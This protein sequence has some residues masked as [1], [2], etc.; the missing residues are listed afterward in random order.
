MADDSHGANA[1]DIDGIRQDIYLGPGYHVV[2]GYLS[3][4][5]VDHIHSFWQTHHN[6]QSGTHVPVAVEGGSDFSR[7]TPELDQHF[8]YFWNRPLDQFTYVSA[9]DLQALRNRIEGNDPNLDFLPH[10]FRNRF[11]SEYY[12]YAAYRLTATRQG[13][14]IAGH[15]DWPLNHARVQ[16]SLMLSSFGEDYDGGL[17]FDTDMHGGSEINLCR[18]ENLKKGDLVIFRYFHKHGVEAVTTPE[19]KPGFCRL[20]MPLNYLPVKNPNALSSIPKRVFRKLPEPAKNLFRTRRPAAPA[21]ATSTQQYKE[22]R[23]DDHDPLFY[24]DSDVEKLM[25]IAV[26]EGVDP[27]EVYYHRGLWARWKMMADWQFDWL[28]NH[29]LKPEHQFLD[30]GC[31]P[32]RLGINLVPYLEDGHYCGVDPLA[33][34]VAL[35]DVYLREVVPQEKTYHLACTED[36]EFEQ[37]DRQFDFALAHAVFTHLSYALIERCLV[38]LKKVMRPGG[39]LIFTITMGEDREDHFVYVKD[40]PMTSSMHKDM[41]LYEELGRKIGFRVE[42]LGR[43][44]HPSQFVCRATFGD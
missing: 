38:S 17:L 12:S 41:S 2:R 25:Q 14:A 21:A 42:L 29:G 36:F 28:R 26:Q 33:D 22:L 16:L 1:L 19:G 20:L 8:G 7:V 23:A 31:G 40:V 6:P 34:F 11:D 9:W 13:G 18:E 5:R 39:Q 24:Y 37:F 43:E 44:D 30:I 15:V 3:P 27:T 32:A 35:G 4:S 10:G